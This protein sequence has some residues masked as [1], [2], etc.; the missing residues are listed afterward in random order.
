MAI[1][2]V[3][4]YLS[5]CRYFDKWIW[6]CSR[7]LSCFGA[8]YPLKRSSYRQC[9]RQS[10]SQ[11]DFIYDRK[12]FANSLSNK[13]CVTKIPVKPWKY[14]NVDIIG[15]VCD[16]LCLHFAGLS[17]FPCAVVVAVVSVGG[18]QQHDYWLVWVILKH[19]RFR[20]RVRLQSPTYIISKLVAARG[21]RQSSLP[22]H[23]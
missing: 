20:V 5:E 10:D 16:E 12:G 6:I 21:E 11:T 14:T 18:Q 2:S 17:F 15:N 4:C 8:M 9:H 7:F 13:L 3:Q 22:E 19:L 1:C 23:C